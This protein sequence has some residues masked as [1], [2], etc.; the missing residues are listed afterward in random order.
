MEESFQSSAATDDVSQDPFWMYQ[1][2]KLDS[3]QFITA[4][5]HLYRAEV[6]RANMW[7]SRLDTTT[8]WSVVTSAAALTFT[9]SSPQNPHFVLLLVLILLLAFLSIEARRYRYYELWYRRSHLIETDFFAAAV[10]SHTPSPDWGARLEDVLLHPTL[11][12]EWW[13]AVGSRFRRN[14]LWLITLVLI[15]WIIKLNVHPTS[16]QGIASMIQRAAVGD[17]VSGPWVVGSVG[18]IYL[19]LLALAVLA[20]LPETTREFLKSGKSKLLLRAPKYKAGNSLATVITDHGSRL[21]QALIKALGRSVTALQGKG[22]YSG[23][24]R[25]VLLCVLSDIQVAQF[26]KTVSDVDPD[27]FVIVSRAREV[28]GTGFDPLKAP[29]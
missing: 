2:C 13:E 6:Q 16:A 8:N 11:R 7:R 12:M 17:L 26:K 14:Y 1:E 22:M 10:S 21:S 25:D 18:C 29:S 4:I 15:S 9:F 20:S 5:V 23:A 24:P 28:H 19:S 27:A 3:S